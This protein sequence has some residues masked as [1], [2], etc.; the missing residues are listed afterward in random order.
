M[1]GAGVAA[2]LRRRAPNAGISSS[3]TTSGA[4]QNQVKPKQLTM[5]EVILQTRNNVHIIQQTLSQLSQRMNIS[6]LVNKDL[7]KQGVEKDA[8]IKVLEQKITALENGHVHTGGNT[9][10]NTNHRL[11][12]MGL[13]VADVKNMILKLQNKIINTDYVSIVKP[14][15][16]PDVNVSLTSNTPAP[17]NNVDIKDVMLVVKQTDCTVKTAAEQL[18]N[19]EGDVVSSCMNITASVDDDVEDDE[20]DETSC[21][22]ISVK[23]KKNKKHNK[24]N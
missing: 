8:I 7:H 18:L 24:R 3:S 5:P 15:V 22:I 2:A 1:S 16:K 10:D 23:S 20:A 19:A 6:E 12:D 17:Y 13:E 9:L 14:D 4:V 11:K 21:E